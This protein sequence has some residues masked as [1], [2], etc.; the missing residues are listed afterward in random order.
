[1]ATRL[2]FECHDWELLS[3]ILIL[4]S[5]FVRVGQSS[6]SGYTQAS[7]SLASRYLWKNLMDQP[8]LMGAQQNAQ[9][10][11][12]VKLLSRFGQHQ[13]FLFCH[14]KPFVNKHLQRP[15]SDWKSVC[16][17]FKSTPVHCFKC[18]TVKHLCLAAF[19]VC[20]AKMPICVSFTLW[21][22]ALL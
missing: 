10:W 14:Y 21:S 1:M 11:P 3:G 15:M 4:G 13:K 8:K 12:S 7:W 5:I 16:R 18:F 22:V 6:G 2:P 20:H 19:L 9:Q 17:W